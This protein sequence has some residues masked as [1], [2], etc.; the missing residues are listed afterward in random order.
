[1]IPKD[2]ISAWRS[3]A[4]WLTDAQ[5]EQDLVLSRSVVELYRIPELQNRLAFRGGTALNKLYFSSPSRYSEDIDLVQIKSE[6]IGETLDKVRSVLDPWLGTP[7]RQ[8][9]RGRINLVY[10]FESEDSPPFKLRLKIEI[11]SREHFSELGLI[12]IP[13]KI[14]NPW[15][16][17]AVEV[18]TYQLDELLG[19]KLRALYQRKKG[20]DLFD[21]WYALDHDLVNPPKL[22]DCFQRYMAEGGHLVTRALFEENLAAKRTMPDFKKDVELLL[23]PDLTWDFD[24]AM[25]I[26]LDRLIATLPGDPWKGDG[27]RE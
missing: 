21:L 17:G 8:S 4:P 9:K 13:F 16:N 3:E 1:M 14:A 2:Y 27:R 18:K 15:F 26:V 23:R 20:R 7:R 5:V 6:P 10:R 22:I 12:P 24:I 25:D 11:N 19:T